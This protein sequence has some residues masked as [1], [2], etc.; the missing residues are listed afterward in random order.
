MITYLIILVFAHLI[1]DFILQTDKLCKMKYDSKLSTKVSALAIHSGIQAVLSYILLAKWNLWLVPITIFVCHFMI[2]FA[3]VQLKGKK[4]PALI[5]DQIIHYIFIFAIWR[6]MIADNPN[7]G[8]TSYL[9]NAIWIVLCA[10][11]AILTPSSVLI[12]SFMDY[13]GWIPKEPALQGMPNA[14]KWIG[15]LERI[16][17]MTFIFTGNVEGIG[18]L[19]AAKSIF[20]FGELNKA[21]D[22]KI[23]EYVLIGTFVSFTIAILI[24]FAAKWLIASNYELL[25]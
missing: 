18:F 19:L 2:D 14:G 7:V 10:Y 11:I 5:L 21:R 22:I 1:G 16:L 6:Y 17:I 3:K 15:F 12:K 23:T 9:S 20:R 25:F 4:L 24:G 8:I 13:E